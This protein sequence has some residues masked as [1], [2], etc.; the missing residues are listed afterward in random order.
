MTQFKVGD[1]VERIGYHNVCDKGK[2]YAG[3]QGTIVSFAAC[4]WPMVLVDGK[5]FTLSNDECNLRLIATKEETKM[6]N[7]YIETATRLKAVKTEV[8]SGN[9]RYLGYILTDANGTVLL[10][11]YNSFNKSELTDFISELNQILPYLK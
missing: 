7:K 11:M 2:F 10:N 5:G 4:G 3:E 9:N 8:R 6:E 1:R